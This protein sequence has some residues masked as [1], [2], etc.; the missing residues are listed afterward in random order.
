MTDLTS[1]QADALGRGARRGAPP[2]RGTTGSSARPSSGPPT[3]RHGA[4]GVRLVGYVTV[5]ARTPEELEQAK[6]RVRT[7][8]ARAAGCRSSGATRSTTRAF[9]NTLP[10]ARGLR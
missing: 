2:T 4:A 3:S 7:A 6:R 10:L 5:V 8:A 1:D 9:T